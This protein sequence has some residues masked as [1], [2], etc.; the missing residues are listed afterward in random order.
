MSIDDVSYE[1]V[2]VKLDKV[3][4]IKYTFAGM[5]I[6]LKKYGSL[7]K[8]L[9]VLSEMESSDI[10]EEGLDALSTLIYAG[11]IHED[12]ELTQ[13]KVENIIDFRNITKLTEALTKALSGS[14]PE[15]GEGKNF[16]DPV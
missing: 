11:L 7:Q 1:G 6:I 2:E 10:T 13:K 15:G 9:N 14:L 3:R 16:P 5:R 4:H 8:A 12:E